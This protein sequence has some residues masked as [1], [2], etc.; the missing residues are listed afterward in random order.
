MMRQTYRN[1]LHRKF[2]EL[3]VGEAEKRS[4]RPVS[5]PGNW[6]DLEETAMLNAVNEERRLAGK[7]NI[8]PDEVR[9]ANNMASGHIDYGTK[10]ALYCSEL[11]ES[12]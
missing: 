12:P 2:H 5:G 3:L 4:E 7:L 6:I 1:E 10:F 11:V 9:K 8:H